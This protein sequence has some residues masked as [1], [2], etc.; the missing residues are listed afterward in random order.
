MND[1]PA[2]I[3]E[4]ETVPEPVTGLVP[5]TGQFDAV[6]DLVDLHGVN[7][8]AFCRFSLMKQTLMAGPQGN[9]EQ[10][11]RARWLHGRPIRKRNRIR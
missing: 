1:D 11:P 7:A 4:P 3:A 2:P 8:P 9:W 6:A 5:S 10:Y